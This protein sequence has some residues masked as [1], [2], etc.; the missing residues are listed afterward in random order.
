MAKDNK[1]HT[2]SVVIDDE[3]YRA[4]REAAFGQGGR[5]MGSIIR[6]VLREWVIRSKN[7]W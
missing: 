6:E 5:S 7:K 1:N 4:V 3:L 2:I